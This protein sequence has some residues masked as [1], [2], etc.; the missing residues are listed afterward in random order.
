MIEDLPDIRHL[1]SVLRPLSP[2]HPLNPLKGRPARF[3][4][5]TL[6]RISAF[7]FRAQT[8]RGLVDTTVVTWRRPRPALSVDRNESGDFGFIVGFEYLPSRTLFEHLS[9]FRQYSQMPSRACLREPQAA[10][11]DAFGYLSKF[12]QYSQ[13]PSRTSGSTGRSGNTAVSAR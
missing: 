11:P 3:L 13:M 8:S 6:L 7:P 4:A 9:K 12:R 1:T 5:F 2:L 10:Q